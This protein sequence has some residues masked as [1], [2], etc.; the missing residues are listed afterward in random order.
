MVKSAGRG[1]K[2]EQQDITGKAGQQICTDNLLGN[3]IE[4]NVVI[5][6]CISL[7]QR[8]EG[9]R[10]LSVGIDPCKVF[11]F[12]CGNRDVGTDSCKGLGKC[13]G[14]CWSL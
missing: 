4:H 12:A 9:E 8:G 11:G 10:D 2:I 7:C 5:E 14:F 6:R 13:F 1:G 3:G